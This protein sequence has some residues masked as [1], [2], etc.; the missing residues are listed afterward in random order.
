MRCMSHACLRLCIASPGGCG[1]TPRRCWGG[2]SA[3][4]K[5]AG[6]WGRGTR[7]QGTAGALR[8][9]NAGQGEA[10]GGNGGGGQGSQSRR[11]GGQGV[12][13]TVKVYQDEVSSDGIELD[14]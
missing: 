7:A 5:P 3:A 11:T 8:G 13:G 2:L 14:L 4:P 10:P 9:R 6:R 1:G 12:P